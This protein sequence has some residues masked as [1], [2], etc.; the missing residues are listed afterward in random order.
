MTG[1]AD[2]VNGTWIIDHLRF[3]IENALNGDETFCGD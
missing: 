3:V 2:N 1:A